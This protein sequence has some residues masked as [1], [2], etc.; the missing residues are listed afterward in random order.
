MSTTQHT[1]L[2]LEVSTPPIAIVAVAAAATKIMMSASEASNEDTIEYDDVDAPNFEDR[3]RDIQ[4]QAS[5]HVRTATTHAPGPGGDLL[6][7]LYSLGS[8]NSRKNTQGRGGMVKRPRCYSD[9]GYSSGDGDSSTAHRRV[10]LQRRVEDDDF[11]DGNE[12]DNQQE[13]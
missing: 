2:T 4:N 1:P 12:D 8:S 5:H 9:D 13:I 11:L 6:S 7:S 3:A 10:G